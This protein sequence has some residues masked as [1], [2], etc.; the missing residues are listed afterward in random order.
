MIAIACDH[1]AVELKK[2][3]EAMLNE[4][5][6]EYLDFGTHTTDSCHYPIFAARAAK[7]VADGTCEKGI[8]ICGTGIGVSI[9]ANKIHGIRCALCSEPLSAELTRRHNNANMLAIGAR[10]TGAELA[11]SIVCTFH[12]TPFDGGR[13]QQR[14]DLITKIEQEQGL[15]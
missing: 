4:M 13:H 10:V 7:A 5:G 9:A 3:V 6:E 14:I 1:A 8:V 15:E 11:K 12:K 2:D